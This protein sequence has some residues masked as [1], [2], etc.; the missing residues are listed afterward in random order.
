MKSGLNTSGLNIWLIIW[1][2]IAVNA[3]IVPMGSY[4]VAINQRNSRRNGLR[5]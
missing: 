1:V 2:R 5:S 4:M 3:L